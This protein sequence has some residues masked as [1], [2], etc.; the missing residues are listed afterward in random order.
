MTRPSLVGVGGRIL[1]HALTLRALG[2]GPVARV[3]WVADELT[4]TWWWIGADGRCSPRPTQA[5]PHFQ[6]SAAAD[7]C[8]GRP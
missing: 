7:P 1:T 4:A 3:G 5:R 8:A 2:V 6:S